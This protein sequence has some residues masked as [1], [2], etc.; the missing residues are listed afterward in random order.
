M[1]KKN[2]YSLALRVASAALL[3]FALFFSDVL[4]QVGSLRIWMIAIGFC[5]SALEISLLSWPAR[6]RIKAVTLGG[7]YIGV[8]VSAIEVS[9][10]ALDDRF[11]AVNAVHLLVLLPLFSALGWLIYRS[12]GARIYLYVFLGIASVVAIL[13]L[14]ESLLGFSLLGRN[15]EFASSQREGPTRALVG[16]EH[17]L[18]LGATFAAA[19]PFALKLK[20]LRSQLIVSLLLAAGC[21]A[22]G[23]RAPALVC[24][25]IA[26]VQLVPALS[27]LL[28]R[29]LWVLHWLV[30]VALAAL[31]YFVLAVWK[32]YIAGATGLD[33]SSN[34]RAAIYSLLPEFLAGHPF[35]YLLQGTPLG[36]W[37]I[38]SE[39]RGP[40]DIA[41]SVDSEII[42]AVFGLGWIGLAFFVASLF[43]AI[44]SIKY[45]LSIGLSALSLTSLGFTL[46]L[47]GWDA[48]SPFWYLLVGVSVCLTGPPLLRRVQERRR[49]SR[50]SATDIVGVR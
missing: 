16:S 15:L 39:L 46:S 11:F 50:E 24:S 41:Q 23:S 42:F 36:V 48:M 20:G 45:D 26:V 34:Y 12:E 29:H 5:A 35:G 9:A 43:V 47:H 40:V 6:K 1:T 28:Q 4:E 10:R 32:P 17:V 13:A 22:T 7:A 18:V 25:L 49:P 14:T 33:Y 38:P 3:F 19:V 8:F 30:V 37:V 31:A 2:T 44:A 27:R 21:W